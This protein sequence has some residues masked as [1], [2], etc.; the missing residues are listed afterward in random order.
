ME[1]KPVEYIEVTLDDID[2]ANS[3][4]NQVLGQSLDELSPP[5]RT[6]LTGIYD[7]VKELADK[8]DCSLEEI[9]FTRRRIREHIGW[10]DWQIRAH[11][12]QLEELEYLWVRMGAR[13]KEY[14][15]A[16]NYRGQGGKCYLNLTP[17]DE[18][19]KLLKKDASD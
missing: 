6:L 1:G 18:I 2:A 5:S 16:L 4:A 7:M 10:T 9:Y 11:I 15:Y 13:G 8:K 3:L 12:R 17:V 14:A 19:K